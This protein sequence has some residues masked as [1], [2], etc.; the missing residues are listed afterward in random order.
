MA[1][2]GPA[3]IVRRPIVTSPAFDGARVAA[4]TRTMVAIDLARA[5]RDL[6][7]EWDPVPGDQFTI[8]QPEL[9][10]EVFTLS[11]MVVEARRYSTGTVLGFNGT[12]EWALDSLALDDA[13]WLPREDQ[14]R[15]LLGAA[16]RSLTL[17][18]GT[19]WVEASD[20]SGQTRT[21]AARDASDAYAHALLS[22]LAE[23]AG[24]EPARRSG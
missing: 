19:F 24:A 7:L 9:T 2:P 14:L 15:D 18:D 20:G 6:G 13:L 22:H 23:V 3:R 4:D 1:A 8:L 10:G 11:E 17:E 12:T 5:L 16:F 21:S